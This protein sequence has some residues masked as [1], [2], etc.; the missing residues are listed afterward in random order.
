MADWSL[1]TRAISCTAVSCLLVLAL[2]CW[3]LLQPLTAVVVTIDEI[4]VDAE[5]V[6]TIAFSYQARRNATV[7]QGWREVEGDSHEFIGLNAP[8]RGMGFL[9]RWQTQRKDS[10]SLQFTTP[11]PRS[12]ESLVEKG[13]RY[14]LAHGERLPLMRAD[15]MDD[16]HITR[17]ESFIAVEVSS[18]DP[19]PIGVP[20]PTAD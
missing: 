11:R 1:R 18:V 12:V 16:D 19:A 10:L 9:E 5:G 20:D 8:T 6:V 3:C 17:Q 14:Y 15:R 2:V 4:G 7:V 13:R